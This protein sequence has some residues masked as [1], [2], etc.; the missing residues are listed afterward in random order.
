MKR[1]LFAVVAIVLL[2]IVA[3]C[4]PTYVGDPEK[5]ALDPKFVGLWQK[6]DGSSDE[7]WA[8]HKMNEH[9]YLV[10]SY[11]FTTNESDKK[12]VLDSTMTLRAWLATIGGQTFV[13]M[14]LYHPNL[15]VDSA[16]NEHKTRYIVA[17]VTLENQTLNIRGINPDFLKDKNINAPEQFEKLIETNLDKDE[18][19]IESSQYTKVDPKNIGELESLIGLIK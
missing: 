15:L 13:S 12:R 14:E 18:L 8:V 5:A 10:Q 7:V 16:A 9:A 19:Y 11:R 3:G 1:N 2:C 6:K 4:L 17:R